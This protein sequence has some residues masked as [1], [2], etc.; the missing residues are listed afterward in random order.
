VTDINISKSNFL[1]VPFALCL[2]PGAKKKLL[3]APFTFQGVVKINVA[4]SIAA[5]IDFNPAAR[6]VCSRPI[7]L[8][9]W[10]RASFTKV[11]LSHDP[12]RVRKHIWCPQ[13][14]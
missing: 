5:R 6:S 12:F 1:V 7:Q 2:H 11:T 13:S 10:T 3:S 9:G 8:Q 4:P 14:R